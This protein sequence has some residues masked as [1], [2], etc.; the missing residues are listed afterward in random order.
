MDHC[1]LILIYINIVSDD[2]VSSMPSGLPSGTLS[3]K[4]YLA[5]PPPGRGRT[6]TAKSSST[7][8]ST[9]S[10]PVTVAGLR[11]DLPVDDEDYLVPSP[12]SPFQSAPP[13]ATPSGNNNNNNNAYMDLISGPNSKGSNSHQPSKAEKT[14]FPY[15]PPQGYFLTGNIS[16]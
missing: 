16:K 9:R 15:P 14:M 11:L 5:P 6:G 13:V 3:Q 2:M 1:I 12:Q 8:S 10:R 7:S 4:S